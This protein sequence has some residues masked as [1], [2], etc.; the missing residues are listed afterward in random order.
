MLMHA[1][2]DALLQPE[3][4]KSMEPQPGEIEENVLCVQEGNNK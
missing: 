2:G 3:L 1:G 4:Y